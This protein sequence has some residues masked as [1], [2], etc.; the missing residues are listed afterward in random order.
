[1]SGMAGLG[2]AHQQADPFERGV[3]DRDRP[4]KLAIVHDGDRV[5]NLEQLVEVL[6]RDRQDAEVCAAREEI[7]SCARVRRLLALRNADGRI[8]GAVYGKWSGTHWVLAD[9]AEMG[10]PPGDPELLSMRDQ[11]YDRWLSEGH[12]REFAGARPTASQS[13]R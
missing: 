2:A 10:Y 6:G 3:R 1:M 4:R 11:L 7:R 8:P 13:N 12:T 9:L 5:G